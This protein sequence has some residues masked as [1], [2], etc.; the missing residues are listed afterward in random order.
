M[1]LDLILLPIIPADRERMQNGPLFFPTQLSFGPAKDAYEIIAPMS[2]LL[3]REVF[4]PGDGPPTTKTPFGDAL[5]YTT[6]GELFATA[7][8]NPELWVTRRPILA[9]IEQ[10]PLHTKLVLWWH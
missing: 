4:P 6:A 7:K 5:T 8:T 1:S 3:E 9:Y 10:L 2:Q